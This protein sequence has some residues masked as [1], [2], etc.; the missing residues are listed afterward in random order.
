V[1]T[2]SD[3]LQSPPES[4]EVTLEIGIRTHLN[5]I[6][7][8]ER[9]ECR[10]QFVRRWHVSA[11]DQ[12]GDDR[13]PQ[14][15]RGRKLHAHGIGRVVEPALTSSVPRREPARTNDRQHH[16]GVPDGVVNVSAEVDPGGD[17]VDIFEQGSARKVV[18]QMVENAISYELTVLPAIADEN[19]AHAVPADP[20]IGLLK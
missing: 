11:A 6:D 5:G 18:G 8:G 17:V 10:R 15:K 4:C 14:P 20:P 7:V 13:P 12:H 1:P 2:A 3:R 16:R 19:I 9:L